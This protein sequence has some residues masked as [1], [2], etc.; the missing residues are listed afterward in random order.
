MAAVL[1]QLVFEFGEGRFG[2]GDLGVAGALGLEGLRLDLRDL[3]ALLTLDRLRDEVVG[4]R[5]GAGD[6]RFA[7]CVSFGGGCLRVF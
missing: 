6:P 5:R 7:D 4:V 1:V 3:F 2:I